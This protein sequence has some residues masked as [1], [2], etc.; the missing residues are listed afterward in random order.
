MV[1]WITFLGGRRCFRER[2]QVQVDD[3]QGR[4]TDGG[5]MMTGIFGG[6]PRIDW[7]ADGKLHTNPAITAPQRP[8]R[9][10]IHSAADIEDS[11]NTV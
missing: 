8:G 5:G 2:R 4:E 11:I 6:K 9:P 7:R 10:R 1:G 3:Q